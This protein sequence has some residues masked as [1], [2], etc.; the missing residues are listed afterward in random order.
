MIAAAHNMFGLHVMELFTVIGAT[1]MQAE[2]FAPFIFVI[3]IASFIPIVVL[4]IICAAI[5]PPDMEE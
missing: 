3:V 4:A 1:V 5:W 2:S